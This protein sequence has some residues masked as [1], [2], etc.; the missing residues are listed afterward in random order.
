MPA[1]RTIANFGRN[2]RFR[3]RHRYVP[4]NEDEVLEILDRHAEGKIRVVA[5]L[6]AWSPASVCEDVVVDLRHF[7]R[8]QVTR[9]GTTGDVR[10]TVGGGT[11]TKR[12]LRELRRRS[13][14]MP[15]L[16]AVTEQTI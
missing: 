4:R 3:P 5:S 11:T 14:T 13:V 9:D 2:I 1:P 7:N 16:A 15:T 10:A 6:H 8:V 12:L